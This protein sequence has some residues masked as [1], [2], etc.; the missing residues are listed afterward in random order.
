MTDTSSSTRVL[1]L[2]LKDRHAPKLREM[3]GAVN[4]V[5][6]FCNELSFRVLQR[7]HRW[8]AS[9]ELQR[10]LNGA[11]KE[12]LAVGSAVFQQVAEEYVTRRR[13]FKKAKLRWRVSNPQRSNYSLGWIPFKTRSLT[14]RAGQ[15]VF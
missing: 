15:V 4:L 13:Q 5:W 6:N 14:Y 12:G 8:A 2:R 9:A 11:S 3:A 10:Y 7:E 1:R